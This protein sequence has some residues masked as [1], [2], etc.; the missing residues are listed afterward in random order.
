MNIRQ[1]EENRLQSLLAAIVPDKSIQ[2]NKVMMDRYISLEKYP[3]FQMFSQNVNKLIEKIP[4]LKALRKKLEVEPQRFPE[5]VPWIRDWFDRM[6]FSEQS[7]IHSI[8]DNLKTT[9]YITHNIALLYLINNI[10]VVVHG[11]FM[12]HLLDPRVKYADI[13]LTCTKDELIYITSFLLYVYLGIETHILSIP[14]IINHRTLRVDGSPTSMC[15]ATKMDLVIRDSIFVTRYT[16]GNNININMMNPII[17]FL[18]YFKM[19]HLPERRMKM[20]HYKDNQLLIISALTKA[21]MSAA[22]IR[23]H[24]KSFAESLQYDVTYEILP[25]SIIFVT[26]KHGAQLKKFYLYNQLKDTEFYDVACPIIFNKNP[27]CQIVTYSVLGSVFSEQRLDV[28]DSDGIGHETHM[29]ISR[30]EVFGKL[31]KEVLADSIATNIAAISKLNILSNIGLHMFLTRTIKTENDYTRI[32]MNIRSACESMN[33]EPLVTIFPRT[34]NP[35]NHIVRKINHNGT[36]LRIP[37]L[38][39]DFYAYI[40]SWDEQQ[41]KVKVN[42]E[43]TYK[44]YISYAIQVSSK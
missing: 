3:I 6:T 26:L 34:K 21:A 42:R 30:N 22:K 4:L 15:D 27:R 18:N 23:N 20:R 2:W 16:K 36:S 41:Q 24:S 17:V 12:V 43:L 44:D 19:L 1:D 31:T 29:N 5:L 32:M 39:N 37:S 14:Y 13:D 40:C 25:D 28:V 33:E 35:G 7:I 38:H 9:T 11:S 10:N 8:P